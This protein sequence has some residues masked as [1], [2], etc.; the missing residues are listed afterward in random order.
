MV[1]VSYEQKPYRRS[2]I[3]T[4]GAEVVPSPSQDTNSGRAILAAVPGLAGQPRDRDLGG[5]RGRGHARGHGLLAGQRAQPRAHAPDRDRAGGD[6][7]DGAGGRLSGPRRRLRRRRLQLRRALVPLPAR[8]DRR[9]GDR[10]ARLRA[11]CLPDAHPRALRLRLRRHLAADAARADAHARPRLRPGRHPRGRPALPRDGAARLAARRRRARA[12][13]GLQRRTTSSP[14]PC[15]SRAPRGS[16]LRPRPRTRS[17]ARSAPRPPRTS[18]GRER[19]I[20]FNLSGHGHFDLGAY[21]AYL[22]GELEDFELPEDEIERALK[23]IE[24]L[25]KP[26]GVGA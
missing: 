17:T 21:D 6:R 26:A 19:T 2:M 10:R 18:E 7:P 25:P 20:L 14:A 23:A 22:A 15:A 5:G 24:P 13:R 12:R 1:K 4:W 11:G 3:Q 9:Q 16:S 8:E